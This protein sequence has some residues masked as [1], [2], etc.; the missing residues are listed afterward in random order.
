MKPPKTNH[1]LSYK[2]FECPNHTEFERIFKNKLFD[3]SE[4]EDFL[5]KLTYPKWYFDF[6]PFWVYCH[7]DKVELVKSPYNANKKGYTSFEEV[8]FIDIINIIN[9]K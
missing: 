9:K 7:I 6:K 8:S 1:L 2:F 4:K 3:K 5:I